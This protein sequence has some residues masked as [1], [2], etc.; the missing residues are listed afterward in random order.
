MNTSY[1]IKN[2]ANI[3]A[4]ELGIEVRILITCQSRE[5]FHVLANNLKFTLL[6]NNDD[7]AERIEFRISPC[8]V[9]GFIK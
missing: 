9:K 1:T 4:K 2:I 7:F 3:Q 6:Y 5:K 8:H